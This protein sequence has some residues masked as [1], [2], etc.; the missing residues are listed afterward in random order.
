MADPE[1]ILVAIGAPKRLI[2]HG[3]LVLEAADVLVTKVR[4]VGVTLDDGWV[5]A[6]AML[7]DAGKTLHPSELDHPGAMHEDAGRVLLLSH[8]VDAHIARC[9]VSH[10]R[11]REMDCALEEL[12]VALA[13]KLWKGVRVA[14]LE[15]LV[16]DRI[17]T[18]LHR[19]RWDVFTDLDT[20]FEDIANDGASRL[21]RSTGM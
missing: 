19:D 9:C 16:I 15:T 17:A 7:H 1:G 21:E 2:V 6:G 13:D 4:H 8:D 11:W 12:L 14:D 5:R 20:C 10:A 18:A 3:R